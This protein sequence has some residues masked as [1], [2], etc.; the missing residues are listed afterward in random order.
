MHK[1]PSLER[2]TIAV[3]DGVK[4]ALQRVKAESPRLSVL[5]LHANSYNS[6]A[7][8]QYAT[9]LA[10]AGVSVFL[11]DTRGNGKSEGT[12]GTVG[13]IGQLEDDLYDVIK[14]LKSQHTSAP[15]V[16]SGHSGG[17]ATMLR[18]LDQY[19][20]S[21]F[22]GLI[23]LSPVLPTV[24]E[25]SRF[26]LEGGLLGYMMEYFRRKPHFL[27]PPPE[28]ADFLPK[29]NNIR[30]QLCKYL[31][32]LR[33]MPVLTFPGD[34]E[35]ARKT[36]R[37]LKFSYKLARCYVVENYDDIYRR[38]RKPL[39]LAI[40]DQ[41]DATHPELILSIGAWCLDPA[42]ARHVAILPDTN[43]LNIA[44]KA[45]DLIVEWTHALAHNESMAP[46]Q[47]FALCG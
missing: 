20:D 14:S 1:R 35:A 7:Y 46:L 11:L 3:R 29:I 5:H 34:E 4:L 30:F 12:P 26:D 17:T 8:I 31:P 25:A 16:L 27:P 39:F 32:F 18:Y 2:I 41:D 24:I 9:R 23:L 42:L 38:L 43:H 21:E 47:E 6:M 13:Y 37:N 36:G 40:G 19:G 15:L 28:T 22:A 33:N 10:L 45:A 44:R